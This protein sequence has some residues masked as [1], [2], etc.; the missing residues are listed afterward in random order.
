MR[1]MELVNVRPERRCLGKAQVSVCQMLS[2]F[3]GFLP[4]KFLLSLFL[5]GPY[6]NQG[7]AAFAPGLPRC[8]H[9]DNQQS[10]GAVT[11]DGKSS[12]RKMTL[13]SI[14]GSRLNC[15]FLRHWPK[16]NEWPQPSSLKKVPQTCH[17]RETHFLASAPQ[18]FCYFWALALFLVSST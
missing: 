17:V 2:N 16:S 3:P 7:S 9:T 4:L 14:L 8:C 12:P 6:R 13:H 10:S 1:W 5:P 15:Q 18:K 11:W